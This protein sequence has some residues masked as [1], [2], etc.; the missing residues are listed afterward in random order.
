MRSACPSDIPLTALFRSVGDRT[1]ALF[2][3]VPG[4]RL[5]EEMPLMT[6]REAE[7]ESLGGE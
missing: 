3:Y 7:L 2:D 4:R 1:Q 5:D 6:F